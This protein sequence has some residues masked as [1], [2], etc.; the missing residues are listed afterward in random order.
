MSLYYIQSSLSCHTT[1]G[2]I[3]FLLSSKCLVHTSS[4]RISD[5][6]IASQIEDDSSDRRKNLLSVFAIDVEVLWHKT[7]RWECWLNFVKWCRKHDMLHSLSHCLGSITLS[8]LQCEERNT[9][10][11]FT[12]LVLVYF[13]LNF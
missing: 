7:L 10:F 9:K 2:E 5:W 4:Q 11:Y 13:S 6:V 8:F 12:F 1:K 3:I